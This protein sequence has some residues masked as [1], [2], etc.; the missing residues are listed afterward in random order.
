MNNLGNDNNYDDE[1]YWDIIEVSKVDDKIIKSLLTHLKD[2][3]SEK[4]FI[5]FESLLKIARK[6]PKLD[7]SNIISELDESDLFT[8]ELLKFI[9]SFI[10][11]EVIDYQ[12][13]PQLYSPDFILR[14][15]IVMKIKEYDNKK[16]IKFLIPL[17]DDPDD[18][19]RW[20]VINY[21]IMHK[22]DQKIHETLKNHINN[23]LNP[24]IL[25]NLISIF[26]E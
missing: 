20:S 23:E 22:D 7:V 12:L 2:K 1:E 5:S 17:L 15:K 24:I 4:F 25:D 10:K 11:K 3:I 8:R 6:I 21:L 16:Y 14:A 18:S 26:E 13:L 19:V 9:L